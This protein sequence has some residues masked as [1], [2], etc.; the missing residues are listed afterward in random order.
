MFAARFKAGEALFKL[1]RAGEALAHLI[2]AAQ[3]RPDDAQ[4]HFYLGR[5]YEQLQRVVEMV[6]AYRRVLELEPGHAAVVQRMTEMGAAA[7]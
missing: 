7:D 3:L 2:R 5:A 4:S 6:Q 1:G